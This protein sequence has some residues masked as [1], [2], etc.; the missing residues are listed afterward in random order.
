MALRWILYGYKVENACFLIEPEEAK[1]V[2]KIFSD[3]IKGMTFKKIADA[4]TAD[5]VVYN[6]DK[7][8]WNKNMVS[9]IIE[10]RH[11]IGDEKYPSI[12]DEETF[13]AAEKK[14][15]QKGGKREPNSP[16]VSFVKKHI[17]CGNCGKTMYRVDNSARREKWLCLDGCKADIYIDD[18][19]LFEQIKGV[20]D[21]VM[22]DLDILKSNPIETYK[23]DIAVVKQENEIRHM[24]D[25]SNLQFGPIQKMI[26]DLIS[27]KYDCC[28]LD[29]STSMTEQLK[30]YVFD[31]YDGSVTAE[32]LINTVD[33][34]IIE[35]DGSISVVFVN[36]KKINSKGSEQN[37][38]TES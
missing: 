10:N 25:R 29:K 28:V 6:E 23:S 1:T 20:Y 36:S 31:S 38:R 16:E 19:Y 35:N 37:D 5:E 32:L 12:I 21:R 13:V 11:Y 9:R 2:V 22:R 33:K 34:T 8:V 17:I 15:N 3:Y 14:R 26:F 27:S 4:L 24:L 7:R 18:K 30:K